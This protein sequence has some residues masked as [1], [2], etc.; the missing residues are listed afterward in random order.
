METEINSAEAEEHKQSISAVFNAVSSDYDNSALRFFTLTAEHMIEYLKP[1]RGWKVLDVATGTG[2][3]CLPLAQAV[4]QEGRV[5][6]IDL[7][8]GM[9]AKA[10]KNMKKVSIE[11]VDLLRMDA[12]QPE[13]SI[14]YFDALTCSFGLFFI[15]DMSK[16]LLQW[17]RMTRPKGVVLFSSFTENAFAPL[18]EYFVEDLVAAGVDMSDKPMASMRL[19]D[20]ATCK[21]LMLDAGFTNIQQT[22]MQVGYHL[23]D[24]NAWW[25]AVWGAAMRGLVELVPESERGAFKQRHLK[26]IAELRTD[27]GLWLDVEVRLTMGQ[28]PG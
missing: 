27:D 11:N 2:A 10:E 23:A 18:G 14:D 21:S 28:V 3:L 25:E 19:K 22:T 5:T 13:F 8:E 26:R 1:Q 6:G 17:R 4:G 20:A 16:A 12:E 9:L 15:P 7:S 24:E